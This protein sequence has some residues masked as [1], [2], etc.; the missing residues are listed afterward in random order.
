M[1]L[2]R[3]VE[4][5]D[6]DGTLVA[7]TERG[8]ERFENTHQAAPVLA[9]CYEGLEFSAQRLGYEPA[10]RREKDFRDPLIS[11]AIFFGVGVENLAIQHGRQ[12]LPVRFSACYGGIGVAR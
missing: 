3:A 2:A 12:P 5:R 10:L 8:Q 4:A 7:P 9:I 6:P 1:R 11:N